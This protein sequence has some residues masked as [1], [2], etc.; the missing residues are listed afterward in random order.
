MSSD[1]DSDVEILDT[2]SEVEIIET[3]TG[4]C[5]CCGFHGELEYVDKNNDAVTQSPRKRKRRRSQSPGSQQFLKDLLA[6]ME[7][8]KIEPETEPV[9]Q[10]KPAKPAESLS[11]IQRFF[12]DF[13]EFEYNP[14]G[15]TMSQFQNLSQSFNWKRGDRQLED[16]RQNLGIALTQDFNYNYG[17]DEIDPNNWQSLCRVLQ[18]PDI[19]DDLD[20]C[21]QVVKSTFVNLVDLVDTKNTQQPVKHFETERKLSE[22]TRHT[23]KFFPLSRAYAGGLLRFLLRDIYNPDSGRDHDGRPQHKR[24]RQDAS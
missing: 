22:Y 18:L 9:K 13:P 23:R 15:E 10:L 6:A 3:V 5:P 4:S 20:V 16:A 14:T 12:N 17:T 1:T 11:F 24:P 2:D 19:P 21:R 8:P 7:R